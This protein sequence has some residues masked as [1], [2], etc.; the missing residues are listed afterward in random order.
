MLCSLLWGKK[1]MTSSLPKRQN[2]NLFEERGSKRPKLLMTTRWRHI[3]GKEQK[4]V[5]LKSV[6]V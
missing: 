5:A 3:S 1:K 2:V 4:L 6:D